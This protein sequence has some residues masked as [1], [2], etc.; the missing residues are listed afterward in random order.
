MEGSTRRAWSTRVGA[1]ADADPPY[2]WSALAGALVLALYVA[3][4]APTTQFWD[5]S[6][7]IATGHILGIPHPPGNPFFVVLA[8]TWDILLAPFGF[9]VATRINL[10]SAFMSAGAHALWFLVVFRILGA[11]SPDR[12]FRLTGAFAAVIVSATAFSVWNQSNVNE[13]VYTVSLFTIALLSW[14]AFRWRDG[15]GRPKND[16]LIVLMA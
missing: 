12:F 2:L 14:I 11:F 3:T 5:A 8:R 15:M 10:L 1:L 13:K 7:Y 9:S 16:N 6:E 4:L